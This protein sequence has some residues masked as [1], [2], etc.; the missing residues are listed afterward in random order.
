MMINILYNM[1]SYYPLVIKRNT[2]QHVMTTSS[3]LQKVRLVL[4]FYD[5][6]VTI[7]PTNSNIPFTY[8]LISSVI[9]VSVNYSIEYWRKVFYRLTNE[10][11]FWKPKE[12]LFMNTWMP[13]SFP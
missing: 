6:L 9:F 5:D 8:T 13:V 10:W 7:D 12:R 11:I 2:S 3:P 4:K 1:Q